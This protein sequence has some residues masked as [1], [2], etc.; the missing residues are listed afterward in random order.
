MRLPYISKDL[1]RPIMR[2]SNYKTVYCNKDTEQSLK[3]IQRATIVTEST[4]E[5]K[6]RFFNK[7]NPS[8]VND[9]KSL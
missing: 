9:S 5:N 7:L 3:D 1:R 4:E 2:R 8:I 6:K